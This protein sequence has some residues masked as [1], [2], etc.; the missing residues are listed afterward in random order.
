MQVRTSTNV[1]SLSAYLTDVSA[2]FLAALQLDR[3]ALM[4]VK[5]HLA[6]SSDARAFSS[7]LQRRTVAQQREDCKESS[8]HLW[9]GLVTESAG[10]TNRGGLVVPHSPTAAHVPKDHFHL[11]IRPSS[12]LTFLTVTSSGRVFA[13]SAAFKSLSAS[14]ASVS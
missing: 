12:H 2:V 5:A 9:I 6:I 1:Y 7:M 4:E 13:N 8:L 10:V 3:V 11:L 14:N